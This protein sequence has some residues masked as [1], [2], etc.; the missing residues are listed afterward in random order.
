MGTRGIDA[1]EVRMK[2]S[3][4]L[5]CLRAHELRY[6]ALARYDNFAWLTRGGYNKALH[7]AEVGAGILV[8]SSERKYLIGKSMDVD[9]ISEEE[10]DG[11]GYEVVRLPWYGRSAVEAAAELIDGS[12]AISDIVIPGCDL[13]ADLFYDLHFPL[14]PAEIDTYRDL[15]KLAEGIVRSV[16]DS[17]HPGMSE[18]DAKVL[19][20][21][22]CA[23]WDIE[24]VAW[25]IGADDRIARYRHCVG[26]W[27]RIEKTL[28]L[29]PAFQKFGL[30]APISRMIY[31]GAT[32][33][34]ELQ[35]KFQAACSIEAH[36]I[37]SC[38]P[39]RRFADILR[40]QKGLYQETGFPEEWKKHFQ[41]GITGYVVNDPSRCL[42]ERATIRDRQTF[43]WYI[44][45]TGVKVEETLLVIDGKKEVLTSRGAWP[46]RSYAV[47]GTELRL[48]QILLK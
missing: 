46:V 7:T 1:E 43:N 47:E 8:F 19:I 12:P 42:D 32:L 29:A 24:N 45:I 31:F 20:Q 36:T 5:A 44:T 38:N 30:T 21:R 41:G 6:A 13:R 35:D 33:P 22:A 25:F 17:L 39:G 18:H 4:I 40:I 14:T 9:R 23:D 34:Q 37:N 10:L 3:R 2:E 11:L 27:K 16:A 28:L 15:G 26:G 48:P